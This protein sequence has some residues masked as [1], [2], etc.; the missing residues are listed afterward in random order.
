MIEIL[1]QPRRVV[2]DAEEPLL[3]Q[4]LL[5]LGPTALAETPDGQKLYVISR[6]DPG[7]TPAKQ[8]GVTV[9]ST[10]DKTIIDA[11]PAGL[12]PRWA[13]VR[14]DGAWGVATDNGPLT[15]DNKMLAGFKSRWMTPR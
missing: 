12:S 11:L 15:T 8:G 1:E 14:S 10:V 6:D 3:E 7:A 4:T 2:A 5:Y 9:I 13:V